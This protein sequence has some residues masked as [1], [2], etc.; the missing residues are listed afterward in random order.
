M[1]T[2]PSCKK[3]YEPMLKREH[4]EQCIQQEFPNAPAWQREQHI[5]GICSDECWDNFLGVPE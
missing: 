2:C 1:I 4:P 5:T 3:Q